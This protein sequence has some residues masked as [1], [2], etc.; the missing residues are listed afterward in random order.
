MPMEENAK[1]ELLMETGFSK[2]SNMPNR[3]ERCI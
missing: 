3:E 2:L 1:T